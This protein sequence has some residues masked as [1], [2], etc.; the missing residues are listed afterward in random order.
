M[1]QQNPEKS[2]SEQLADAL[3]KLSVDQV[4]YVVAR[5]DYPTKGEAAIAIG[6]KPDTVYRWNGE[7]ERA[8][9]LMAL[10]TAESAKAIRLR[11][12]LKAMA[13]KVKGLDSD[14]EALRQKVATELIEWELGKALQK[15]DLTNSDGN[16]K[17]PQI[18]EIVRTYEKTD[19]AT[20]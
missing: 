13:I 17:P 11:N 2:I 1:E 8:V 6:L 4:R 12:L 7:V 3:K 15:S 16:L 5:M 14:D 18:I 20:D 9:E 10:D 19:N